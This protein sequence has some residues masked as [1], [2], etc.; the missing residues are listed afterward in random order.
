MA[1]REMTLDEYVGVLGKQH[2]AAKELQELR[3]K[4]AALENE[5]KRLHSM[6]DIDPE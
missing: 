2:Y 3:D 6:K 5:N 1:E 4:L